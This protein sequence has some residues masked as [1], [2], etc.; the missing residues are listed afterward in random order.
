LVVSVSNR[1]TGVIGCVEFILVHTFQSL[2]YY[3][4]LK[5]IVNWVLMVLTKGL[6]WLIIVGLGRGEIDHGF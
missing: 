4:K 6:T 2:W 1:P 3:Y 5:T